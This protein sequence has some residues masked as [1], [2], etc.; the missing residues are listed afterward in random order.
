[1]SS[2]SNY[3]HLLSIFSPEGS[4]YQVE[5]SYKA[6]KAAG[7]TAIAIRCKDGVVVASQRKVPD[8]LMK[9][10]SVTNVF[11][12]DGNIGACIIGRVPDG[13]LVLDWAREKAFN[14][15]YD[16]GHPISAQLLAKRLA[17]RAQYNTQTAEHRAMG[18][19]ITLFSVER[20]DVTG[21]PTPQLFKVDPSGH[22]VL[23]P[24]KH[25]LQLCWLFAAKRSRVATSKWSPSVLRHLPSR[26]CPRVVLTRCSRQLRNVISGNRHWLV[27]LHSFTVG[28][29][30][31]AWSRLQH[32]TLR[33]GR[34]FGAS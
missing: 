22:F 26:S 16:N 32:D 28:T 25:R 7:I 34:S 21:V 1:M 19:S 20:D 11:S 30:N 9:P 31:V 23:K 8:K 2:K 6:V 4:L 15:K 13:Q 3:D 17:A 14:F 33:A 12:V 27:A 10:E 24:S 18:V 5:Y 29:P